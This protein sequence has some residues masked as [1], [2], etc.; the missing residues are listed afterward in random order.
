MD[1]FLTCTRFNQVTR[2]E[3]HEYR[4]KKNYDGCI[5]GTPTKISS[6]IPLNSN[7]FVFEMD[8]SPGV[9]DII[10]IGFIKNILDRKI[11][12]SIYNIPKFN[13]YIY[14]SNC[15]IDVKD[16]TT[17]ELEFIKNIQ[18]ALFKTKSH[19]QRSVG[20][21]QIPIKNLNNVSLNHKHVTQVVSQMFLSRGYIL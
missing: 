18:F 17:F 11:N 15:R 14:F 10:G 13:K 21:T 19:V 5:Y 20:I 2:I 4:R 6:K 7:L 16:F 8:I 1:S 3:N 12:C 9:K